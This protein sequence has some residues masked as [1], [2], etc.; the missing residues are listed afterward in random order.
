ML[1]LDE[2]DRMLDMGFSKPVERIVGET[3]DKRQTL[4][5]SATLGKNKDLSL[6][7]LF[8]GL[9]LTD[10]SFD[11]YKT[12]PKE[13]DADKFSITLHS[14]LATL[15]NLAKKIQK[16]AEIV[17]DGVLFARRLGDHPANTMT[18]PILADTVKKEA[19][20]GLKVTIWDKA[21]LIKE[22]MG[23]LVGVGLG[24]EGGGPDPR[25]ILMEYHGAGK[26]KKPVCLVGKGLTFDS[27]GICIKP[28][29][30]M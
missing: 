4:L 30:G 20:T 26:G 5:F 10:Y 13:K 12:T 9:Y 3:P 27:G 1:V 19:P 24:S 8:E 17:C 2:A 23:C 29:P 25:L 15:L 16:E 6:N 14:R 7:A 28:G 22:K 18:P 21:R 11:N